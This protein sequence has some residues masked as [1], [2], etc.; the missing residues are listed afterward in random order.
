MDLDIKTLAQRI[1]ELSG[2]IAAVLAV[3]AAT[4]GLDATVIQN[5]RELLDVPKPLEIFSSR[6]RSAADDVL[7]HL[8][9]VVERL[10]QDRSPNKA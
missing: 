5:A 10:A 7:A 2:T 1:D 4:P 6:P 3:V 8:Q 9:A